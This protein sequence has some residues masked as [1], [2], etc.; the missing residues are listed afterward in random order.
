LNRVGREA[1]VLVLDNHD[2]F[3][4]HAKRNEFEHNGRLLVLNGGTLNIESPFRYN[5]P[6]KQLLAEVGIDLD[7]YQRENARNRELYRS[8][9]LGAGYFFDRETWGADRLVAGELGRRGGGSGESMAKFLRIAPLS[10]P[11]RA[12]LLR[13]FD[14]KQ[15]D[16]M[17]GLSSA[18]KKVLLA[19]M[20]YNDFV[21][22]VAKVNSQVLWFFQTIPQ[23]YFC[24]GT[25]ATPALFCW[26]M[27]LPG[28][29]GMGLEP[30]PEGVL[31]DL[32]GG[33]HGRQKASG[34]GG[35]IHFPD[36][37]ATVARLIVRSLI[38]QAV[39]GATME[40]VGVSRVNYALLDRPGQAA[41]IRLNSTVV[42]VQ[43]DKALDKAQEVI[44]SYV[45]EGKTYQVRG[46]SC[47]MA[48]WNM[49][50]PYLIPELP[51]GQ[52][53]ALAFNVKGPIVYSN[54]AIRNWKAFE[55]ISMSDINSP[56]MY[57][58]GISL[59]EAAS[60]GDLQH[61]QNPDQPVVLH[62]ERTPCSPGKPRKEQHRLGR[63]DLLSTPF[64]TF[65]L[66]IRDQLARILGP[67]GFD[68]ATDIVAITV[69][70]WPHGYSYTYNSLYDPMEWV[71]TSSN[72]RPCVIA[73]QPFGLISIANAD[74]AASPHTDA[75]ILEAHR[76][77]GEILNRRAMPL[78]G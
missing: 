26:E 12:D 1:R 73:R 28:F 5:A 71:F 63:Y 16:Y 25:D 76:A 57:H 55:K 52:K 72:Q 49:F 62:L 10:P 9:G 41:R 8:F 30:T 32:P 54:V 56:T 66:K 77:V 6:A 46:R 19:K 65:E 38:P 15:P 61:P 22:N 58:T 13:L 3:G 43:H 70:R 7:R 60:L 17:P 68:P 50:I 47:V 74:A 2:D 78:L 42:N 48:C 31:A 39:P 4:G 21:L 67:G 27:G 36:G 75:A 11:A 64:S 34:G 37:N 33:Q 18:E 35:E 14:S 45:R 59:A 51:D 69:N 53:E 40:D 23:G 20:S 44:V 24:V 29:D